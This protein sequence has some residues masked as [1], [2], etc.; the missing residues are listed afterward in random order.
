MSRRRCAPMRR[1][2]G[3]TLH[4]ICETALSQNPSSFIEEDTLEIHFERLRITGLGERFA[5]RDLAVLDQ[6]EER[7]IE[8]EHAVLSAGLDR[9]RQ[10]VES[11]FLKKFPD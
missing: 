9:G 2:T 8:G 10:F 4:P 7:L 11:I 1:A 3:S 6:L 5:L